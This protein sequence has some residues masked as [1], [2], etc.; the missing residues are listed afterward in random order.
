MQI[1]K[2]VKRTIKAI[3]ATYEVNPQKYHYEILSLKADMEKSEVK[4]KVKRERQDYRDQD[5]FY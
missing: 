1:A 4:P 3:L 2:N 5:D